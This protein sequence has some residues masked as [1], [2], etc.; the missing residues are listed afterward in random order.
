[1]PQASLPSFESETMEGRPQEGGAPAV[2]V[3]HAAT[4]IERLARRA[5]LARFAGLTHGRIE[6]S[7]GDQRWVLGGRA[8]GPV[9]RLTILHPRTWADVALAGTIGSGEAFMA[10]AW[11]CDDLTSLIRI[12][13]LNRATLDGL[14][15]GWA[16]FSAPLFRLA[17]AWNRNTPGGSRRNIS[18]HYDLGNEFFALFLD[19]E[20]MYS[21]AYFP[22]AAATLEEASTAKLERICARLELKPGDHLLEIGTGWGGMAIHAARHHGCRVTTTTISKRQHEL[23]TARVHAAGLEDRVTVL[24]SDYRDLTGTYDKLVSIEMIEAVGWQ[25]Y[26]TYFRTCARLLKPAGLMVIQAITIADQ[27]YETAKRCVDFIQRHIFP[28]S[29]IPSLTALGNAMTRASDLRVVASE[30]HAPHYARTLACWRER[31][32]AKR[33]EAAALGCS[34]TFLRM[35]EFYLCYC[36]GGFHERVLGL[37]HLTIAKPGYRQ[38]DQLALDPARTA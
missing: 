19:R 31:F 32:L 21:S 5:V 10:G 28:G 9:A 25:F 11:T 22:S 2:P 23:A 20:M 6:I 24:L 12:L 26:E 1:M 15:G 18:A 17:H 33:G 3:V 4:L 37:V 30:D 14:E 27:Q 29:C 38:P 13:V 7:E 35:W 36:E 16:R 8:P 34:E